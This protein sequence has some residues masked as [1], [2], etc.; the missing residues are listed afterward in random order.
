MAVRA[1]PIGH[2][3]GYLVLYARCTRST[4]HIYTHHKRQI[5]NHD[6]L[7]IYIY[8]TLKEIK[9]DYRFLWNTCLFMNL[10]SF[11]L[12]NSWKFI[13]NLFNASFIA[14]NIAQSLVKLVVNT[15]YRYVNSSYV[16]VSH[17]KRQLLTLLSLC[18]HESS[19]SYYNH[20][21][22]PWM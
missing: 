6:A 19:A 16:H 3:Y 13:V 1:V 20:L 4:L 21:I 22:C 10:S 18:R 9:F 15:S 12:P 11:W 8:Y 7:N 14:H 5:S 17:G 2:V